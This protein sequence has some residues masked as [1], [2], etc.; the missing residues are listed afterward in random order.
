MKAPVISLTCLTVAPKQH[1]GEIRAEALERLAQARAICHLAA[2]R[3]VN[4]FVD[5]LDANVLRG[6]AELLG[7]AQQMFEAAGT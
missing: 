1:A 3:A 5:E 6:A 7:Q 2:G 4:G